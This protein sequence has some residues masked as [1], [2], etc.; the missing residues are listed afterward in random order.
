MSKNRLRLLMKLLKPTKLTKQLMWMKKLASNRKIEQENPATNL[1]EAQPN[2][3]SEQTESLALT[4]QSNGA[5]AVTVPHDTV[6][7]AVEEAKAEGVSTV[8]DSPMD[9][10]NTTSA[11]ETK[12]QITKAEA[13]AQNQIEAINEVTETYKADK[14]AYEDEKVRI[15]QE[16]KEL[17][18]AYEGANQT[19]KETN[20]W[21]DTKVNDLKTRYADADVT[22]KEQVVSS[23]NGTSVLDY[24]NYG[25]AVET[26]QS[27]NEQAVADYLTKKT[28]ADDIV[29]KNQAIQKENEAGLAKA[30]ADNEAIER[31]NQVGQAA[32]DAE[33]RTGQAA[34]D[35]ANQEKQQLVSDR[36]AE[37]EAITK[38]NK[39]KEA[40]ARKENEAI[41]AYNATEM[42]RYQRDLAEISKGEEGYISEALAQALNLN[43]GEPQAQHGAI[44]RNPN[45]I[46]STGDA[47][48]GG[49]S[50]ILDSTG[51]FVYDSFKTGET[52]SFNYQNLQ[53]ARF[54]GKK[55]SRVTYDITNLVSPAGTNAVK[56]VVPNDPTEGFIAYRN[57][58]NG[59]W[60]TDKMEFR[61]VAKYFLEDGSQVTFSKEKPGVFTHSSLNHN[62]IGL[63]YVKDT[64]GKFVPINGST[65][66]VTNEG[67]ARSLGSNRASDLNLPEEW[68]TTSSR[69]AYK[70][71]IVSTVTSGNT[72]TVTFGQGDMPQNVGLSYWFAL[73]T[74]PVAR[75][76]TPYSPKPHV[77]VELEPI[78]EPITVTPD[79]FTPKTFTPEKPVTFTP[80]PLDEVVQP[81]LTLT[82]VTLPVKLNNGEPQAQ[83]GAI[84]RNPNQIIS[85]GDAMLGGYSRIL[86]STGFFV[87]DSFKTGETLS[88]NYQNLQHARFDGKKISRVTYD[89]TN[90]VSPAGTNAV[91]LVVPNDPTEGFIAYR[92]DGNGDWRTDKMEFRV[93]AKYFLEDG[94]QVT[95]SKEKPGV[96]THSSL[97]H[98][99]I[100]LEYVK[101]TSGKFVPINGS[102][103]QVTNEGLARS[104]GSN[105][106]SD[107]NLPEEW[108][109]TSSRYAY[110]GAIVSTV[111]SGNTYTVTF[112]QG[113]MP[114]NVGLSYWFALNT[115]PVAR[116]VTPYSPK[117]HVTV[118]LEPI[119]E[120]ITV[121]PDVFTPKTFTPEKPVT[122][123]PKPLD[124]VVQ[125]SL[126]LTKVTLP[127]KPIPKELPT[128]PQVPTVHYH[129][130]RLTTT[131]EI[132]KEVVNSDQANLHEKTVA[133]DSTV[134][135]PLTVDALSPNR[136]QTTSLIFEDYLPAGYLFDKE[137]TQKENRNYVLSFDETKNFVTLT[138]KENLLQEVNK[139]L[140]KFYQL[141]APKLYGSVQNDGATYSNSYKL[142]LNKGTT[143]AYTVTS[144][145]VTVRTPGDGETTTLITPDKNNENADGVLI[146]DTV[147]ALGTTNHYRLIWDLDQYKGERSAK[148]TIARGFFFV[149]DYPEEVLDVVEN[150]T[151][152]TTLD[153]QKV[154]GI[155]VKNY[156]S[157]NEAPKDLQ[158]K[159][160]RAKITP[161]GAFQVY[162]PDDNQAFYDQYVQTGTSLA[163]LTKMTVKDSLYGQTKTYTNKAYQVDFGNGYETKEVT[164][165]LVS[166]E[167]KKQNLNK[168]KVDINGKP[169]LVG[170]QNHYTLSW[171]LDQYRGIKADNTQIAQGFYFV[172]DYPE[173]ALLPD[174]AA[175][176]FVTS[177]GKTVS[178]ITVKS[179]SQFS[180]APKT[181]QAAFSKQKI[182][183]KGAFQVFM[184][185]DPQA[186]FESYVTKGENITIVT[187]MTV[188]ET[189]LNSGKSYEN[190]AYQVDFG[191]AYET[192]TVTNFVPKVT[193]H[194][195]NTNQEGIS[196]D[197]KTILPNTVNYYKIVLDYKRLFFRIRSIIT[198]LSWITVNTRI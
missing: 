12:Q 122:F 53:H 40:A 147:V 38:R 192:N 170:S 76:V 26:I 179:Y 8:E 84:T 90:L 115:L 141:T 73:N 114:Q 70:G 15:E 96:F 43:N 123:T 119:S 162:L 109:T 149:D 144:N 33:N 62:D 172:D 22:V 13:D 131:P 23:G 163:L 151:A 87:Y 29:A 28:K 193:P 191:Q 64:S 161:T 185:E 121:T 11:T 41:D 129:A 71:A 100:G 124:E 105:R 86:D 134:I 146:N 187:P 184:P 44:T 83:H 174:E 14:A 196:I 111:T 140:T 3:V 156:A 176:Q 63:E 110:K 42:E 91:K 197:G 152:V 182:Q 164:N 125:P 55:I 177:D 18:Q 103:V 19:G 6:T 139:D 77:T 46:I 128:P 49:Y 138:A 57:D 10:G 20:A 45:Q 142:L 48:L 183:P 188:L 165:T 54:D 99:D 180:E 159:L 66:Q 143:N 95:F 35:Q 5:I 79:V 37:I 93:V 148:D 68:D 127:V 9:L 106:A 50:R 107:L 59:D 21:V 154:S 135:Y 85:T 82:K 75:T 88:F 126:T 25:K 39:E 150:G 32:V 117:P 92:N 58:G 67:L 16:N 17:S 4:G 97:N 173:E 98:N 136:A 60:R 72:Y 74:L 133:K 47:M 56:L 24:T 104:L 7:Q 34:V 31:R 198:K 130:Y 181:L 158:D 137:T 51:F 69:Y 190:V 171:D 1:P 36:A 116:T 194:K 112:G 61:V 145:V 155:T 118:E 2:P 189:M 27:T 108:D 166:P 153:G 160:A 186:F 80:K 89:I 81:S 65:V 168:D 178:G 132:M 169:M 102:T 157:L 94:S 120:P 113:D 78:S 52:L 195:S 167:P 101:D 175:I 30:K